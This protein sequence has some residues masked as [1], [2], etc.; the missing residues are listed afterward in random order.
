MNLTIRVDVNPGRTEQSEIT[1]YDNKGIWL[2]RLGDLSGKLENLSE[3]VYNNFI[4]KYGGDKNII[5]S[6]CIDQEQLKSCQDLTQ[7]LAEAVSNIRSKV[8]PDYLTLN[9]H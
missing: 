9:I 8:G 5:Y 7:C 3:V 1:I 4:N 2:F 6:Y